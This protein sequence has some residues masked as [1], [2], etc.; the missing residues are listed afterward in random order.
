MLY[1]F[2]LFI[3]YK[4]ILFVFFIGVQA[5]VDE[6]RKIE[7]ATKKVQEQLTIY[8]NKLEKTTKELDDVK[9]E[10]ERIKK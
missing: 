6:I 1:Y 8:K 5:E 3:L 10:L 7:E 2:F 9:G 4:F